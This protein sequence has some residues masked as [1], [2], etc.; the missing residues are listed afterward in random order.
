VKVAYKGD[1]Q[2]ERFPILFD[3][4]LPSFPRYCLPTVAAITEDKTL[5]FGIDA[6]KHLQNRPFNEGL[7][8]L[9]M[10][11]AGRIAKEFFTPYEDARYEEYI[12]KK[13]CDPA[14]LDP[15]RITSM[16]LAYAIREVRK[17]LKHEFN[18]DRLQ[19]VYNI[20]MPIHHMEHEGVRR[21]FEHIFA[22]AEEIERS[23]PPDYSNSDLFRLSEETKKARYGRI[24][25][26]GRQNQEAKVFAVPESV[27]QAESYLS[28][29]RVRKGIH[30]LIDLGAGT[31]DISIFDVREV[32]HRKY[33]PF[34]AA[35]NIPCGTREIERL[36]VSSANPHV[37]PTMEQVRLQLEKFAAGG[38]RTANR[39]LKEDV[40]RGLTNIWKRTEAVWCEAY[41]KHQNQSYWRGENVQVFLCGGGSKLPFVRDVFEVPWRE[42]LFGRFPVNDLPVPTREWKD[43]SD[44]PF[45]RFAVAYGLTIPVQELGDYVLP[46]DAPET[47]P[48]PRRKKDPPGDGR[49]PL[50]GFVR[51]TR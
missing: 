28:S 13:G 31:S 9:K 8:A 15:K 51:G 25:G 20:N 16:Y 46:R 37:E 42:N 26:W 14:L 47:T 5:L 24:D 45:H 2:E 41:R 10:V 30:A 22:W 33:C 39:G 21:A 12:R 48:P 19:I 11:V 49:I 18:S 7:R 17:R 4:D 23:L 29:L 3:H 43:A 50:P 40:K 34:I 6:E 32:T 35:M 1:F 36:I 44:A 27:A 38:W